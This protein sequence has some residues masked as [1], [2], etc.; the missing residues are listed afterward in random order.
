MLLDFTVQTN[1]VVQARKLNIL[2]VD[3]ELDHVWVIDM[4]VPGDGRV[5]E[6]EKR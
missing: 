1:L 4:A 5:E 2:M 6:K 3:G